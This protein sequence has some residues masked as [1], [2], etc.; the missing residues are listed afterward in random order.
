MS[1]VRDLQRINNDISND[2]R[3]EKDSIERIEPSSI[4]LP[5]YRLVEMR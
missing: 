1:S 5:Q 4:K 2:A 3:T